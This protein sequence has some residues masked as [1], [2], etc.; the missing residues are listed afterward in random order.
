ME[1][2]IGK[3]TF[4]A[5]KMVATEAV[6]YMFRIGKAG[7]PLLSGLQ[8][9]SLKSLIDDGGNDVKTLEILSEFFMKLD[10][11]E[12]RDLL[13]QLSEKAEIQGPQGN[14]EPVIFDIHFT[15]NLMDAFQ[16][17]A[18]VAQVNFADFFGGKLGAK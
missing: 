14:Y 11:V 18:L 4:R 1:K 16:V 13:I 3:R 17:A 12:S 9:I 6:Q 5:D 15:E 10:P 2:K 8:G 7:A